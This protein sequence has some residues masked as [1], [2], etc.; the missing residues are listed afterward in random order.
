MI[1]LIWK[2]RV[3]WIKMELI[4]IVLLVVQDK[5]LLRM[6]SLVYRPVI[7]ILLEI[8]TDVETFEVYFLST[9]NIVSLSVFGFLI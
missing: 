2:H 6:F 8:M 9:H 5:L 7:E 1:R 4:R 3:E